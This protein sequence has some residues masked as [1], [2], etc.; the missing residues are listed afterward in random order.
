VRPILEYG[1]ACW[2]PYREGQI[3][4]LE[5]VQKKAAKFAIGH[6]HRNGSDWEF[7]AQRRKIARICALFKAYT[8]ER[9]WKAT[10]ERLQGPC[11]LSKDDHDRKI[12]STKQRTDIGKYSFVNRTIKLWYNLPAEALVTFPC[13][14]HIFRKRVRELN[15][16]EVK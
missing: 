6:K 2:D 14:P 9:T 5:R 13:K 16:S 8:G 15:I 12:R 1:A 4:A 7:L 10:G 3:N 11:Y